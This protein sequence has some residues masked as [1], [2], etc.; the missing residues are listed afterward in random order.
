MVRAIWSCRPTAVA[1]AS[2]STARH[3]LSIPP[4]NCR[5]GSRSL[6]PFPR[7]RQWGV[8]TVSRSGLAEVAERRGDHARAMEHLDAAGALFPKR[9]A[10]LYLDQVIAKKRI[11]KA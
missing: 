2:R 7:A 4:P 11:M 9:G 1:R 6:L 3:Q 5:I 10:K 8:D